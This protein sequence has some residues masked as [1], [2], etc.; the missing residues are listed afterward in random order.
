MTRR[1][2]VT[3]TAPVPTGHHSR[4]GPKNRAG[5]APSSASKSLG[6]P[7]GQTP[8]CTCRDYTVRQGASLAGRLSEGWSRPKRLRARPRHRGPPD[9]AGLGRIGRCRRRACDG[10]DRALSG[11]IAALPARAC[12]RDRVRGTDRF[13][14]L[15]SFATPQNS[16]S[17]RRDRLGRRQ[18]DGEMAAELE[19][20]E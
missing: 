2:Y 5:R 10:S 12:C 4:R 11:T 17:K 13:P 14:E 9:A 19:R 7:P 18:P 8:V 3:R 16:T 20:V 1:R 15:R 6:H